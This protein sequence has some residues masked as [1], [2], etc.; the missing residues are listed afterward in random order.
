MKNEIN[1]TQQN[2]S[3]FIVSLLSVT[4]VVLL[5]YI[6]YIYY[7]K[8][9]IKKGEIKR[10]YI[11]KDDI[12]FDMLPSY[13]Q[14][15]YISKLRYENKIDDMEDRISQLKSINDVQQNSGR[16]IVVDKLHEIEVEKV[17]EVEKIVVEKEILEVEK[18]VEKIVEVEKVVEVEKIIEVEKVVEKIVEIPVSIDKTKYK[19]FTCKTLKN[20]TVYVSKQCKK[21]LISFLKKNNDAKMY[22]VIGMVDSAEFRLIKKLED[23]YGKNKIGNLSKYAQIGLSRKRVIEAIWVVKKSLPKNKNITNVNYTITSKDKRGFVVRA[24]K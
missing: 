20:G 15:D 17:V 21:N 4:I 16:S 3:G 9:V 18:V 6:G 5:G 2:S 13:V 8:D 22:E 7:T 24:Y 19:T 10:D 12:S 23:V 14:N 1:N 11:K